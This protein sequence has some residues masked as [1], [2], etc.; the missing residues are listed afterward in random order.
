MGRPNS[1]MDLALAKERKLFLGDDP[2]KDRF[3]MKTN[4]F[5]DDF[6]DT[7]AEGDGL[8]VIEIGRVI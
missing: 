5:I 4:C 8:V 1:F 7:I 6:V 2:R 3:D